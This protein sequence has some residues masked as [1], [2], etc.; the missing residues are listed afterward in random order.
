MYIYIYKEE[1]II[2]M[3][4][5]NNVWRLSIVVAGHAV[6]HDM[7]GGFPLWWQVARCPT[8]IMSG[9]FL[10][11]ASSSKVVIG[12][13]VSFLPRTCVVLAFGGFLIITRRQASSPPGQ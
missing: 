10:E 6:E 5:I 8:S 13:L 4:N 1:G 3:A 7:F 12:G 11:R 9:A 2:V